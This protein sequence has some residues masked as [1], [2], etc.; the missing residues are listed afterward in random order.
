[1]S[2]TNFEIISTPG[3]TLDHVVYY[4]KKE[5]I[6]FK[7]G[8]ELNQLQNDPEL[9]KAK[10]QE[11]IDAQN[12]L[13]ESRDAVNNQI[14]ELSPDQF[15]RLN[16]ISNEIT[17]LQ[18]YLNPNFNSE[19]EVDTAESK[20]K[21]LE[22]E[23]ENIFLNPQGIDKQ[24]PEPILPE[25]IKLSEETQNIYGVD[26]DVNA[27]K[28]KVTPQQIDKI[29]NKQLGLINNV[30]IKTV[31]NFGKEGDVAE[32]VSQLKYAKG[33]M[34]DLI[35]QYNPSLGVPLSAYLANPRTGLPQRAK[36][37]VKN[38]TKQD[39]SLDD[40]LS[41]P[42]TLTQQAFD[43]DFDV[44]VG[45]KLLADRIGLPTKT[46]N[47]VNDIVDRSLVN[48]ES[49]LKQEG[50]TPKQRINIA[51]KAFAKPVSYTHLTLPTILLV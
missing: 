32:M 41:Q 11:I 44:K 3:H 30:A 23:Q 34:A 25:N 36:R 2:S 37:I 43:T 6:L 24:R 47:E 9:Y 16:N 51:D 45:S 46:I 22:Q 48:V 19:L 8:T 7:A 18:E 1:M 26:P 15:E 35:K 10:T 27:E 39:V 49:K 33:G 12:S 5:K 4:S 17:G 14:S 31:G 20:I 29:I 38:V 40:Q 50:L 28:V 13:R 42:E 21:E